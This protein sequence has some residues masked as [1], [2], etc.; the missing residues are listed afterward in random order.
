MPLGQIAEDHHDHGGQYLGNRGI[1]A[2]LLYKKLQ[3]KIIKDNANSYHH[4]I[5]HQLDP[6]TYHG[7]GKYYMPHQHEADGECHCEG[8]DESRYVRTDGHKWQVQHLFLQDEIVTDKIDEDVQQGIPSPAGKVAE[9]LPVHDMA[10]RRIEKIN[11]IDDQ[12]LQNDPANIQPPV[13]FQETDTG[14]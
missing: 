10:E 14:R 9:C 13:I 3:E 5:A 8:N 4:E 2:K 11:G 6:A 1:K 12:A 7:I